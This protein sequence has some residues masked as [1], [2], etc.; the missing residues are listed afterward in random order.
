MYLEVVRAGICDHL[1]LDS[2]LLTTTSHYL[3]PLTLFV[4]LTVAKQHAHIHGQAGMGAHL[5]SKARAYMCAKS[6]QL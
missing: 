3:Q 1:A 6:L 4:R 2:L 5:G